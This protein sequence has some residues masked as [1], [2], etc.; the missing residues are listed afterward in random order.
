MFS[1]SY[2][3]VALR[4]NGLRKQLKAVNRGV[5]RTPETFNMEIFGTT[6]TTK[7]R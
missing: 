1:G 3:K 7:S 6:F 5:A 4:T 2:R